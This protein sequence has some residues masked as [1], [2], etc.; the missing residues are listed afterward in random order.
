MA[1]VYQRFDIPLDERIG[2]GKKHRF[3][4]HNRTKKRKKKEAEQRA[5]EDKERRDWVQLMGGEYGQYP[6]RFLNKRHV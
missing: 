4:K 3:C 1:S 5:R 6:P 2:E